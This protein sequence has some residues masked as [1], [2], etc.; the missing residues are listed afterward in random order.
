MQI[1]LIFELL[2]AIEYDIDTSENRQELKI[3]EIT[4][5]WYLSDFA[6]TCT[7]NQVSKLV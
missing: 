5:G 3:N 2:R 1:R 6:V 7:E 4:A